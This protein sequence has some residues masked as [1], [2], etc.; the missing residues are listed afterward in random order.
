[1]GIRDIIVLALLG[2]SLPVCFFRPFFG[3]LMWEIVSFL[4]PQ[5]FTFGMAYNTPVDLA[6]AIPTLAGF[7]VFSPGWKRFF[8]RDVCL[9]VILWLWFTITTLRN[10]QMPEF[11]HF[12]DDTWFRWQFVSKILLMTLVTIAVVNGWDRLRWLLI[13]IS[14]SFGFLVLKAVPFMVI[15]GGSFRLYGPKGSMI[16]DNNDLGLALNMTLPMFFFLAKME[17]NTKIKWLMRILVVATI[18]AVFFTY[19]RG[20]LAGLAVVLFL[21]VMTSTP[22]ARVNS[23]A[24]IRQPFRR[25]SNTRKMAAEN[26]FYKTGRG[27]G[28]LGS[29]TYQ[30]VA[31]LLESC[32]GSSSDWRR[33]R[34]IYS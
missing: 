28:R 25:L 1:M 15:T 2:A 22:A 14:L 23:G 24:V 26:E 18:P 29:F 11:T 9:M 10:T 16:A 12:A 33:I 5:R 17:S 31:I 20:A 3:I 8:S 32:N 21:M 6:V 13:V 27:A 30:C 7:I 19:S 34:S 4:N